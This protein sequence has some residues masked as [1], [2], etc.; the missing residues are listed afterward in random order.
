[1]VKNLKIEKIKVTRGKKVNLGNY[2]S[3]SYELSMEVALE[4]QDEAHDVING[5][6]NI[7][8]QKLINWENTIKQAAK[9]TTLTTEIKTADAL[10]QKNDKP[11]KNSVDKVP[12]EQPSQDGQAKE[13]FICPKCKE[14]MV[15]KENKEYFLCSKHWGY[16]DMIEKGEVRDKQF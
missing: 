12:Q 4:D 10:I 14:P 5:L 15:K 6:K 3:E 11:E 2:E 8:D 1:M 9:S 7:I 16:P 13:Q